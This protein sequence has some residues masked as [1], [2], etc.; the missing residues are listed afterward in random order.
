MQTMPTEGSTVILAF[1][2]L[3]SKKVF[4]HVKV[5]LMGALLSVGRHTV[6]AALRFCGLGKR[7]EL[8][9]IPSY[10]KPGSLVCSESLPDPAALSAGV[11]YH[12][13]G[14]VGRRHR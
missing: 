6:C 7:A 2:T 14:A 9:Q 12:P 5:L 4:E 13:W 3:F 10:L 1:R 11:F 8:S